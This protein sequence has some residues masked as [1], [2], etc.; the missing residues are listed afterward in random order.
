MWSIDR[1]KTR[2]VECE[3]GCFDDTKEPVILVSELIK[4]GNEHIKTLQERLQNLNIIN[5][6]SSDVAYKATNNI[7]D[8][9]KIEEEQLIRNRIEILAQIEYIKRFICGGENEKQI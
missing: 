7:I 1:I 3:S 4:L 2:T 9:K 5:I 8:L 6:R